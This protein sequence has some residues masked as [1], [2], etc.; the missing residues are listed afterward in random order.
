MKNK[1][2]CIEVS[3]NNQPNLKRTSIFVRRWDN[4]VGYYV[5]VTPSSLRRAQRAQLKLAGIE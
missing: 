1:I 2:R 5:N 4:I 3:T